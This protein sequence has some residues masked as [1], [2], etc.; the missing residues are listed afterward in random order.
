MVRIA[1][2]ALVCVGGLIAMLFYITGP[3]QDR[4]EQQE[5]IM[6]NG[7]KHLA[8]K[9][10]KGHI[11]IPTDRPRRAAHQLLTIT[12]PPGDPRAARGGETIL[13]LRGNG[14]TLR[15]SSPDATTFERHA[16]KSKAVD[17]ALAA[18]SELP[19]TGAGFTVTIDVGKGPVTRVATAEQV[20]ALLAKLKGSASKWIPQKI[21]LTIARAEA[22]PDAPEW[23]SLPSFE[24]AAHAEGAEF[25]STS[26]VMARLL[27]ALAHG[28]TFR[29][30]DETYKVTS[31]RPVFE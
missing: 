11:H 10:T 31:W 20:D 15:R 19:E 12:Y 14:V 21:H 13:V 18:A 16:I 26:R 28:D 4:V 30:G 2:I 24:F 6:K 1:I 23:P 7:G 27:T 17:A 5:E 29:S 22:T 9:T 25:G 3:A 8:G